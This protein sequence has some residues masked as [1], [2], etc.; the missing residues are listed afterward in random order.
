MKHPDRPSNIKNKR[1]PTFDNTKMKSTT[2]PAL[3]NVPCMDKAKYKLK[4]RSKNPEFTHHPQ[5]KQEY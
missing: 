5:N 3:S 4:I 2:K 1:A